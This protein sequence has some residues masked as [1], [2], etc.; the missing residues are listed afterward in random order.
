MWIYKFWKTETR[1]KFFLETYS[2]WSLQ[3]FEKNVNKEFAIVWENGKIHFAI[4]CL[5]L[6]VT[7]CNFY[8]KHINNDYVHIYIFIKYKLFT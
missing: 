6:K 2:K 1:F 4:V 7:V 5:K 3:S 8:V